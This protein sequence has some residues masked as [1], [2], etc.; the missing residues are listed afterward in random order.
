MEFGCFEDFVNF[1]RDK[2]DCESWAASREIAGALSLSNDYAFMD[3][4]PS[5]ITLDDYVSPFDGC[6]V[7]YANTLRSLQQKRYLDSFFM[8]VKSSEL[9]YSDVMQTRKEENW[10]LPIVYQ[11]CINLWNVALLAD[12]KFPNL[13]EKEQ[14][15]YLR[16]AASTILAFYRDFVA[17][18]FS[19]SELSKRVGILKLTNILLRIYYTLD[20]WDIMKA[21]VKTISNSVEQ[22]N[23]FSL[24][25][26]IYYSYYTGSQP[27]F[28]FTLKQ[29]SERLTVAFNSCPSKYQKNRRLILAHLIP[30]NILLGKFPRSEFLAKFG[31]SSLDPLLAA[32]RVG[33]VGSVEQFMETE[34]SCFSGFKSWMFLVKLRRLCYRNLFKIMCTAFGD[35]QIPLQYFVVVLK[36]LTS[37]DTDVAA[38]E[39]M[40]ASMIYCGQIG[41]YISHTSETFVLS[42]NNPFPAVSDAQW[43]F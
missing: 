42:R 40:L 12:K 38:V 22:W 23:S 30:V 11:L 20:Q 16:T 29:C 6:I 25:D 18:A 2:Y 32:I 37:K 34:A 27:G 14:N 39:S 33:D 36:C 3:A 31:F 21:L 26:K 24:S 9:F 15:K 10:F 1:I 17:D 13:F 35:Y 43:T 19:R 5:T 28:R 8:Q 41:G 4:L 7:L